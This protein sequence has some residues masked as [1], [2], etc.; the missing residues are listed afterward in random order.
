MSKRALVLGF[1]LMSVLLNK[2]VHAAVPSS[3]TVQGRLTDSL[4]VPL[5]PGVKGFLFRIFNAPVG[6]TEIWS[7]ED[8]FLPTDSEGL[9]VARVGAIVGLTD[10]VFSDTVR[11]LDI[12]VNGTQLPRVRLVTGPYAYRVATVDGATGGNITSKISIGVNHVNTGLDAFVAGNSNTASGDYSNIGGG[13]NNVA[14]GIESVIGGGNANEAIFYGTVIA[15]GELNHAGHMYSV[16]GGG[17]L[18]QSTGENS[19]VG[20]GAN[21]QARG[22]GTVVGGGILNTADTGS[23]AVAGGRN[24]RAGAI[25]AFVGGGDQN[26]ANNWNASVLG[27]RGNQAT[28]GASTI[29]GGFHNRAS[30]D[31]STTGGGYNNKARGEYSTIAGGGGSQS[32][33]SNAA[34]GDW[35]FIGGGHHN[36]ADGDSSVVVGGTRNTANARGAVVVGGS[37]NHARGVFSFIGG[38][39]GMFADSNSAHGDFSVAVGG[40][41]A[42]SNGD[43]SFVGGGYSNRAVNDY[44]LVVGGYENR[45]EGN[46][47][48]IVGGFGN[49]AGGVGTYK[50]IGGGRGNLVEGGFAS[51]VSGDSNTVNANHGIV[52]GGR[53]NSVSGGL[54]AILGG[55]AN[56]VGGAEAVCIGGHEDS[57]LAAYSVTL[58]GYRNRAGTNGKYAVAA[59]KRAKANHAGCFVWADSTDADFASTDINQFLIRASGGVGIGTNAPEGPLHVQDGSAGA[60]TANSNSVAVFESSAAG[61]WISMLGPTTQERGILFSEPGLAVAGAIVFDHGGGG[62]DLAFRTGGNVTR[63]TLDDLGNLNV[64]GN[65]TATGTCCA[66]DA[67][68]KKNIAPVSGALGTIQRMRGVRYEWRHEE[69]PNLTFDPGTHYGIIAQEVQDVLPEIVSKRENG[70]LGVDYNGLIPILLEAIK[71]QQKQIEELQLTVKSMTP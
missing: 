5:P 53:R 6:G 51:I 1:V 64:T 45:V 4:G 57:A 10:A 63:M 38:G 41:H 55:Q 59:G 21:N 8:Q 27:G 46:Y 42:I 68:L 19:V 24:N 39:G 52:A 65:I 32:A 13:T 28:G 44:T 22:W 62:N 40:N 70:Y 48:T 14:S 15:G 7:G 2:V 69:H 50:F 34:N 31:F 49:R 36:I 54:S 37:D 29:G 23:S 20:G 47:S 3:I 11:W 9:W 25:D 33:D 61:H 56:H 43:F 18:N 60:I 67:Q 58:G 35:S 66:S 26:Q 17:V 30:G 71:E 16:I 12:N